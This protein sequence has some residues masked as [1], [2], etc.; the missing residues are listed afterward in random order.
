MGNQLMFNHGMHLYRFLCCRERLDI[1]TGFNVF[2]TVP[3]LE[4]IYIQVTHSLKR[5]LI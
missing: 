1:Q 4:F 3:L 5:T 2:I